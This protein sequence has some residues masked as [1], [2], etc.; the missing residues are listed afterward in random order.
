MILIYHHISPK[1]FIP[2]DPA[3]FVADGWEYN[4]SPEKFEFQI[5]FL[6]KRGYRFVS[7]NEY[8]QNLSTKGKEGKKEVLLTIDDG[9]VDNYT[10][11]FPILKKYNIPAIIYLTTKELVNPTETKLSHQQIFEMKRAGIDFGAHTVNHYLLTKLS[12][13]DAKYE[14]LESKKVLENLLGEPINHFAYPGG[15][16]NKSISDLVINSGFLTACCSLSPKNNTIADRFWLF[17]NSLS[18]SIDR[19]G[20]HLRLHPKIIN[21]LSFRS[22]RKLNRQLSQ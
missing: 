3:T 21:C 18:D 17:R 13:D 11:A 15:G 5:Q 2:T 22:I 8:Y 14:I 10:F 1:E 6:L 7:I 4:I 19:I 12:L 16:F 9:W 20:D